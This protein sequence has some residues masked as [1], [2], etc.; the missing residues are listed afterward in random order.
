[1]QFPAEEQAPIILPFSSLL[2][3]SLSLFLSF[4]VEASADSGPAIKLFSEA[5]TMLTSVWLSSLIYWHPSIRKKK[6]R[7]LNKALVKTNRWSPVL[8]ALK[9]NWGENFLSWKTQ[10]L[11]NLHSCSKQH[12]SPMAAI[13]AITHYSRSHMDWNKQDNLTWLLSCQIIN[14]DLAIRQGPS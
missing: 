5:L 10:L 13:T 14:C 9:R 11:S 3:C 4:D 1:M 2:L 12:E 6:S 7:Q 8:F